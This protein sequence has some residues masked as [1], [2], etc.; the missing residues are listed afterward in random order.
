MRRRYFDV[1]QWASEDGKE[2]FDCRAMEIVRE[3]KL[4]AW[5]VDVQGPECANAVCDLAQTGNWR[6]YSGAR[7]ARQYPSAVGPCG[8]VWDRSPVVLN[9]W[10][11]TGLPVPGGGECLRL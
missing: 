2:Q 8:T 5:S 7:G 4:R 6:M 9:W 1:S 10:P 11:D 3:T